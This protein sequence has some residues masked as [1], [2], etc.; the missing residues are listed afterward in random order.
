[1][2][3][4]FSFANL[5]GGGQR[6]RAEAEDD[7]KTKRA[8]AEEEQEEAQTDEEEAEDEGEDDSARR[9]VLAE[10]GRVAAI[11][12]LATPDTVA[13]AAALATQTDLT[14]DQ[15]RAVLAAAP[16]PSGGLAAAMR[17]R[18]A[19]PV[20]QAGGTSG[21]GLPPELQ[22]AQARRMTKER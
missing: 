3:K 15:A 5:V 16:K 1:M 20:A 13:Q 19:A 9:A 12:S 18:A 11:L 4:P 7:E 17:G 10:R 6:P 14:V 21:S 2:S 8:E 22:A